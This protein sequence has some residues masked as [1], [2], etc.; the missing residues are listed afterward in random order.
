[1]PKQINKEE[2]ILKA[3]E[4]EFL[5]KGYSG[6]KT[7]SIAA[8]AGVTH[9]MLHYYFKTKENLFKMIFENKLKLVYQMINITILKEDKPLVEK[10]VDITDAHFELIRQNP[11]LPRFIINEI[12]SD[13]KRI[14][15]FKELVKRYLQQYMPTVQQE[16][17]RLALQK[18]IRPISAADLFVTI[19]SLNISTFLLSPIFEGSIY[20]KE[21][22]EAFFK[23]R[24]NEIINL[25]LCRLKYYPNEN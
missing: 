1:M 18:V 19:I 5:E 20:E 11:Q 8:R 7:T 10:L 15:Y 24:K 17:D 14:R 22:E 13:P 21:S 12:L 4:A 23:N 9:A 25:I 3:A 2:D 6:A 16:I